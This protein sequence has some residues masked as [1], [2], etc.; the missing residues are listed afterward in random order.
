MATLEEKEARI[1]EAIETGFRGSLI[2]RGQARS[3]IWRNGVL[4]DDAPVFAQSLSYDLLSYGYALISDGLDVLEEDG[5]PEIARQ[6]FQNGA[7]ALESVIS[8]GAEDAERDFYR[9]ITGAAY[10]LAR[11]S[12]RAYSVLTARMDEAN[13]TEAESCLALLMLRDIDGLEQIIAGVKARGDGDDANLINELSAL[14]ALD[15]ADGSG[16]PDGESASEVVI[17]VIDKALT[18]R[19]V[20]AM[21]YVTLAFERGDDALLNE[22]RAILRTGMEVSSELSM[23]PQWWCHRLAIYLLGDLWKSSFHVRLPMAP[24]DA[25]DASWLALRDLFIA[26]LYRRSRAEIDLWPSQLDAATRALNLEDNMIV[27]LPTSAGKTRIA[28]LCILA[29]LASGRRVIFVTPL[30]ALSAQTEVGLER[31]FRPLG[32]SVSSLYGAI[33][34]SGVDEDFLR[35][36]D[37]IVA[38][39]EKLDFALRNDPSLLDDVGLVVLDEGH[40]IGLGEREVRYEVQ[41]QKLLKRKDAEGRRIACLSAILPDGDKLDDFVGWLS[42]GHEDGLIQKDWRPTDLRFGEIEWR[43]DHARMQ[44]AVG[45]ERPYIPRFL[46]AQ[47]PSIGRRK[48]LFPNDQRE[49]CLASAWRLVEDGQS[50]LIFCPLRKSVEPFAS[51][52]VNLHKQGFLPSVLDVDEAELAAAIAIGEEWFAPDHP[53]LA[54]L[55]L[56]VAVHHGALPTPYRREVEALLRRGV[57]KITIS[58]PTLAQGLN[59]SATALIFHGLYRNKKLIEIAEFRNVIGRAGRAFI[60][61]E[62]LVLY[63]MFD[64]IANR[65]RNWRTL[66]ANTGG[67]EME[68]GLLL[69]VQYLLVRM[70]E[71]HIP[72]DADALIAYVMNAGAW[73]FPELGDESKEESITEASRWQSY[74]AMLDTAI[75]GL[76]GDAEIADDD[77]EAKLDEVLQSSLWKRRLERRSEQIQA[78]LS[79][80]L[81]SRAKHVWANSTVT[82]RRAYFLAGV[83][84]ETG[85]V[86]DAQ[87][88]MLNAHLVTANSSIINKEYDQAIDAITAFAEILFKIEPFVPS[89]IPQNWKDL[90]GGWLKGEKIANLVGAADE[91]TLK[92]IEEALIYKLPWGMEAVRVRGLAHDDAISEDFTLADVELGYAVAAV[93]TGTLNI[94]AALLMQSGFSSRSGAIIAVTDGGGT[95]ETASE[96]R[97]WLRSDLVKGLSE[98][99]NWPSTETADLWSDFVA[100]FRGGRQAAWSRHTGTLPVRWSTP[101]EPVPGEAVRIERSKR[102]ISVLAPDF[103]IL[104]DIPIPMKGFNSGVFRATV[105]ADN[106]KLDVVYLGPGKSAPWDLN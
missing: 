7:A 30:R 103:R 69:L 88:K 72:A 32:K 26:A 65:Q 67:K 54:C 35:E 98:G 39:P 25:V 2:A 81:V 11:Y 4:P 97:A 71:K 60:D 34:V 27:S 92:F 100:S 37:I 1:G 15:E 73:D 12:A 40:M 17:S 90:L 94:S 49:F 76:I 22:A 63:P 78:I 9:F 50:V 16:V 102:T 18:D 20:T 58:S 33:G 87:A 74:L 86:L 5:N 77:V 53:M 95:F 70:N 45:D 19:F 105:A 106:R 59:L 6:A 41:I 3:M 68:S 56:G 44:L 13:L 24:P 64:K 104:G 52:V 47:Q 93:E 83:G 48:K 29:C 28:E 84:L 31:T 91:Q 36:R 10:H 42:G 96:M 61:V 23:V 101:K 21:G 8:N 82:Q 89:S 79:A 75:L 62:G 66:I 99:A 85:Q 57:L 51:A 80:G 14:D 46:T 43:G 38:T 55:K